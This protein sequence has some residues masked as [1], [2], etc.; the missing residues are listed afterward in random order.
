MCGPWQYAMPHHAI[1]Q[2]GSRRA[3]SVYERIA[4]SV[5][6]PVR[7]RQRW[8]NQ[9]CAS[10]DFVVTG[11]RHVPRSPKIRGVETAGE[12]RFHALRGRRYWS[13]S[14]EN[15]DEEGKDRGSLEGSRTDLLSVGHFRRVGSTY[16]RIA[17]RTSSEAHASRKLRSAEAVALEAFRRGGRRQ[18]AL[19]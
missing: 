18:Q 17:P 3:A 7:Q 5:V 19:R 6:E 2:S 1:A 4:S 15:G 12:R 10:G 9:R 13:S 11:R 16:A 14:R 8:S